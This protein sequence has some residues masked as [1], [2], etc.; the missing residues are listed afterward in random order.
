MVSTDTPRA[1]AASEMV[2]SAIIPPAKLYRSLPRQQPSAA[3]SGCPSLVTSIAGDT[4]HVKTT[5]TSR[6]RLTPG[7]VSPKYIGYFVSFRGVRPNEVQEGQRGNLDATAWQGFLRLPRPSGSQRHARLA[8]RSAER[9][10][11][12]TTSETGRPSP[13]S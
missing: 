8:S 5:A 7:A 11:L 1:T 13:T 4:G 9:P 6:R 3:A 2:S 10:I 12:L